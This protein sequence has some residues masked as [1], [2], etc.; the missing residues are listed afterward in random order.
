MQNKNSENNKMWTVK[1][2]RE[3]AER[4][5]YLDSETFDENGNSKKATFEKQIRRAMKEKFNLKERIK[6][7]KKT[8]MKKTNLIYELPEREARYLVDVLL[9]SYFEQFTELS[10]AI[11]SELDKELNKRNLQA[12][13]EYDQNEGE[14]Y[15]NAPLEE[16]I[17]KSIDRFMLR[18]IFNLFYEFDKKSYVEDYKK[19]ESLVTDD[20]KEPYQKGYSQINAKLNNPIKFYCTRKK[21]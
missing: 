6:K 3:Y 12:L 15:D 11:F 21:R 14:E 20:V 16:D 10:Q 13:E 8:G 19:R 9:K 17:E 2:I 7:D 5:Y 1:T 18:S 4:K